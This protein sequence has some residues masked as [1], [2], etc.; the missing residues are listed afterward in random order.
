MR[1]VSLM[2]SGSPHVR[3]TL[4][5]RT[6]GVRSKIRLPATTPLLNS[7][8]PRT[9]RRRTG[10]GSRT[11]ISGTC[12]G[13][14]NTAAR[15]ATRTVTRPAGARDRLC[16]QPVSTHACGEPN[17][18]NA[19]A[20]SPLQNGPR[21]VHGRTPNPSPSPLVNGRRHLHGRARAGCPLHSMPIILRGTPP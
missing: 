13:G 7:P 3:C 9:G 8:L 5:W 17:E 6:C 10:W 20:M 2:S 12:E 1:I 16:R 21:R 18:I 4:M 14:G 15:T 11:S 19:T